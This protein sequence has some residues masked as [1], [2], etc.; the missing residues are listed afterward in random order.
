LTSTGFAEL[1][2]LAAVVEEEAVEK[3]DAAALAPRG[4][5]CSGFGRLAALLLLLLDGG[6]TA[7]PC[8]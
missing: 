2:E 5:G 4:R 3:P 7:V 1:V 8:A 6:W